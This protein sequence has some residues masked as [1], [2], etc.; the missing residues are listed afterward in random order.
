M[1]N[2]V[3]FF[4]HDKGACGTR[5][6]KLVIPYGLWEAEWI[7]FKTLIMR[8]ATETEAEIDKLRRPYDFRQPVL[9]QKLGILPIW[10][11]NGE[12]PLREVLGFLK[13][14]PLPAR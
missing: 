4:R 1:T 7:F 13:M 10:N 12:K 9:R 3:P 6:G 8:M 11:Q 2:S 5:S 14:M